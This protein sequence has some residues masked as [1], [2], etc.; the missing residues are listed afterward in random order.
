MAAQQLRLRPAVRHQ[1]PHIFTVALQRQLPILDV[2]PD[3]GERRLAAAA[4][5]LHQCEAGIHRAADG[6]CAGDAA[7][8]IVGKLLPQMVDQK[9]GD[10]VGIRNTPQRGEVTVV[11]CVGVVITGAADHLQRVDD[12]QHRVGMLSKERTELLLQTL[13]KGIAVGGEVDVGG[14]VLRDLEQTV[15]DAEGGVL[16]AEIERSSL[17]HTHA[18]DLFALCHRDGQPQRQPRFSHL[19]RSCED[20]QA[21]GQQRIHHKVQRCERLTH[22]RFTVD[23]QQSVFFFQFLFLRIKG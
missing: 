18:P 19:W 10:A 15:L 6:R 8:H 2:A 5:V 4:L 20:V 12:D 21:L 16:Q 11:I 13:P 23:G 9:N 17:L 7:E 3:A 14:G 22:Q 1:L